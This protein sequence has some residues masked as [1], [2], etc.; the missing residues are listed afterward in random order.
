FF[1]SADAVTVASTAADATSANARMFIGI[2]TVTI[3]YLPAGPSKRYA[4]A[5]RKKRAAFARSH[6]RVGYEMP[7]HCPIIPG[8]R[9]GPAQEWRGGSSLLLYVRGAPPDRTVRHDRRRSRRDLAPSVP[10][11]ARRRGR[12]PRGGLSVARAGTPCRRALARPRLSP[13]DAARGCAVC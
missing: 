10:D 4:M 5:R 11:V 8:R 2:S 9:S 3:P 1:A 12:P 13:G 7:E 6:A